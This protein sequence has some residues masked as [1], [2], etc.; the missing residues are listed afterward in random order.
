MVTTLYKYFI[1][2]LQCQE[3]PE[4]LKDEKRRCLFCPS[5]FPKLAPI[6][7]S[8]G[9][10]H[11]SSLNS[12]F[13]HQRSLLWNPDAGLLSHTANPLCTQSLLARGGEVRIVKKWNFDIWTGSVY[14]ALLYTDHLF[15]FGSPP[16]HVLCPEQ[17][18]SMCCTRLSLTRC[19][20]L[21]LTFSWQQA[22][23]AP[24]ISSCFFVGLAL[25]EGKKSDLLDLWLEKV[26]VDWKPLVQFIFRFLTFHVNTFR[27]AMT[28]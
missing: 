3:R 9:A 8:L 21:L 14:T 4:N 25:L 5:C 22:I 2:W 7:S 11:Q 1:C 17:P 27:S 15:T 19:S 28:S 18:R 6:P 26:G 24:I 16:S 13:S 12:R 20:P 23:F 10:D